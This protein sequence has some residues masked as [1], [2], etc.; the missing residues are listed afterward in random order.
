MGRTNNTPRLLEGGRE[1]RSTSELLRPCSHKDKKRRKQT[2][3]PTASRGQSHGQAQAW[4]TLRRSGL[5]HV[6][7]EAQEGKKARQKAMTRQGKARQAAAAGLL[8]TVSVWN[9]KPLLP[10]NYLLLRLFSIFC[11]FCYVIMFMPILPAHKGQDRREHSGRYTKLSKLII[12]TRR[13]EAFQ[14]R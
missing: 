6:R 9:L 8:Y 5:R 3:D 14:H 7:Q 4:S 12:N 1:I 2:K 11:C 13:G 10:S